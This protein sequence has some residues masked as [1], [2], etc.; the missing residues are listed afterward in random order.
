MLS[1]QDATRAILFTGGLLAVLGGLSAT[2]D[3]GA[4][5]AVAG[6]AGKISQVMLH[7]AGADAEL[8]VFGSSNAET[9]ISPAVLEMTTGRTAVNLALDG[10]SPQQYAAVA[11]EYLRYGRPDAT[12]ILTLTAFSLQTPELP[13]APSSYYPH[14]ANRFVYEA[15]APFDPVVAWRALHVPF[16]GFVL[17]D[18][19]Y[20]KNALMG[21]VATR[22]GAVMD[23]GFTPMS[24]TWDEWHATNQTGALACRVDEP[25]LALFS[26]L[27]A[28]IEASGRGVVLVFPPVT[29][30][31]ID[32]LSGIE[33]AS[34]AIS[35]LHARYL[36]YHHDPMGGDHRWFYNHTHLNAAGAARFSAML[37]RDLRRILDPSTPAEGS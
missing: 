19:T 2:L 31:A 22:S 30:E 21:L 12:V 13:T 9:G 11:R 34:A 23:S 8:V 32:A 26:S 7:V 5:H 3:H 17:H 28:A 10:T 27:L 36:D 25:T 1:R 35:R 16:Y 4:R 18:H 6:D 15:M 29:A 37:G 24:T 14:L 20:Y 33:V